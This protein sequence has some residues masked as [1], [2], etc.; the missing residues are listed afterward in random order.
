MIARRIFEKGPVSNGE[1]WEFPQWEFVFVPTLG[2][3]GF[4]QVLE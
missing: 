1:G 2:L 4:D 3:T